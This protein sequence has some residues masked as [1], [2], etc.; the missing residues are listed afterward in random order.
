MVGLTE[1]KLQPLPTNRKKK[2]KR[3]N[4]ERSGK[5]AG[6][7]ECYRRSLLTH[8]QTDNGLRNNTN[9]RD[10]HEAARVADANLYALKIPV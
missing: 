7:L 1:S 2:S 9:S 4:D 6:A 8:E 3:P 10:V 5:Q